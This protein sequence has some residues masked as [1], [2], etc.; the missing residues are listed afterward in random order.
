MSHARIRIKHSTAEAA[1]D[2]IHSA[3]KALPQWNEN[4]MLTVAIPSFLLRYPFQ[5]PKVDGIQFLG[6]S[7]STF[8]W[9]TGDMLK[10]S[11]LGVRQDVVE[12]MSQLGNA[13]LLLYAIAKEDSGAKEILL[14]IRH[15][16][17]GF[18]AVIEPGVNWDSPVAAQKAFQSVLFTLDPSVH[19]ET[20]TAGIN[21]TCDA[22]TYV[23]VAQQK[24]PHQPINIELWNSKCPPNEQL[25]RIVLWLIQSDVKF[26]R[27][28]LYLQFPGPPNVF[29][30]AIKAINQLDLP[31]A[32]A[33]C[34]MFATCKS[35]ETIGSLVELD[36]LNHEGITIDQSIATFETPQGRKGTVFVV[37]EKKALV[38]ELHPR[39]NSDEEGFIKEVKALLKNFPN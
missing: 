20:T 33:H 11:A 36:R 30:G 9:K 29:E 2:W 6:V 7:S 15:H 1:V 10:P 13:G 19:V 25:E 16:A 18:Y 24:A 22:E 21:F 28:S 32:E 14:A 39:T 26:K 34:T 17:K 27:A 4:R 8:K 31:V 5:M 37:V 35:P 38:T 12:L 3:R 23:K